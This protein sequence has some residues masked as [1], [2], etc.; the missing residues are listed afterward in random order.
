MK[1]SKIL[2]RDRVNRALMSIFEYPL[3]IVEA[4]MGY[5]KTTAVGEFLA[6]KGIPVIWTS[7]FSEGD[8]AASYWDRLAAEVGKFDRAA[9]S[10]L[11]NLGFPS[12]APQTASV[13]AIL[14]ELDYTA[15]TTLVVDDFHFANSLRVTALFRRFVMEMPDD[16]H[17]VFITRDTTNL[18]ISELTAKG[19]C[20]LLPQ[21]TLRFTVQEVRDYCAFMAFTLS[22]YELIRLC[23]YTDGWIS[24]VYL[25]LLGMRQGI[26]M[27]RNSAIDE[28]VEKAL[29]NAYEERIRHFLL[30]LSV[31][32]SFT[33]EQAAF[34]TGEAKTGEFLRKLWRENA[35]IFFDEA[36]GVYK[37]HNVLLDFLRVRQ[38][39]GTERMALYRRVGEWHLEKKAYRLSYGYLCRAGE[40][41]R[42]LSLL[43][44]EDTITN[45]F[46]EFE[47]AF[48]LFATAPR[49]MLF[50]YPLAYLQY[51]ALLLLS[52]EPDA[53]RDGSFRLDELQAVFAGSSDVLPDRKNRVLAEINAVRIFAVFNDAEKMVDCTKQA[54]RLLDG[55]VSCLMKRESEF[56]FGCP[57]FLYTYYR[58]AGR[59]RE[60]A[61]FM[62]AEFP[63]FPALASG[64]GT[65][66][67]I[68]TLAECAL[69]TGDWQAAELNAFKAI[70]KARTKEQTGIALCA[71]LTLIRLYL[72][73]GRIDEGLKLLRQ[74]KVDVA[75]EN[76]PIYNTTLALIEGYVYGCLMRLDS[77][78]PW[79]QSG[80]MSPAHFMHEGMAFNYIVHGK[81]VL[82]SKN[83]IQLEM[84][85]QEFAGYFSILHNQLGF[86]HNQIFEAAAKY[87]LY[88]P[89]QGCASL[90]KA[91]DMARADHILLPFAEYAP[92][93]IDML[94]QL[95]ANVLRDPYIKEVLLCCEQYLENLKRAPQTTASLTQREREV[96]ALAAEGLKRNE[97]ADRLIVSTG[98]VKVHLENIYRKLEVNGKAAA[99]KKAQ[100]LK[101]LE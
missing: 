76:H 60:T 35:F 9:G 21:H 80:D 72:F 44:N 101:I 20:N 56:T 50:Q 31:M 15:H 36:K 13:I 75:R 5:G 37:I 68:V 94:R 6:L 11:K 14:G 96:L 22:E 48:E 93:I 41:E 54:L 34:V 30:R 55:G 92:A 25:M 19:L 18:D 100:K 24:L 43:D 86:L 51:I 1:K 70:Y 58:E 62:A 29:Y 67:D 42:I 28:L 73:Q 83:Y 4:P 99:V 16:F 89:E 46:A 91:L 95:A 32:D 61:D 65:G 82:L 98:T 12:D 81:A 17:V 71:N 27:D 85:T 63:A 74:L 45:D 33:A 77:I 39:E 79:L 49:N 59:L 3:T 40:T 2:K 57:H 52:G 90:Q 66:S 7:F 23:E 47:G 10:K 88:G 26:P 87:R 97:I 38:A 53:A 69:E 84:L 64:C 8:T 78:P